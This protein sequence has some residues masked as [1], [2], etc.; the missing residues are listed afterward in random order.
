MTEAITSVVK[1][2][3]PRVIDQIRSNERRPPMKER[4]ITVDVAG[5][6][7]GKVTSRKR[8]HPPAPSIVAAS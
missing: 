8:C 3:P 1:P 5:Q 4:M 2:G 7:S 6:T